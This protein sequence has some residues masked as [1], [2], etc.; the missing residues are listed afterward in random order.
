MHTL[1]ARNY[2]VISSEE[3]KKL[4]DAHV[5]VVGAGGVGGIALISLA[6]M[7][8][9]NIHIVDMDVFEHSNIN[10]QMLSSCSR[11]GKLKA[12]CAKE[13]LLDINPNINVRIST[14][15]CVEKN[16]EMLIEGSDVVID[17]TDTLISRVIIHRTAQK[18][19]I[20]SVWIAVTPPFRGGVM[21]FSDQTPPYELVLRHPSYQQPLTEEVIAQVTQIKNERANVS[22]GFGALEDWAQGY[23]S[24]EM[25]W[26]VL[27]P[28]ANLVGLLASFEAFKVI[29][30]RDTL[31]P[32]Y[33]PNLVKINLAQPEMVRVESPEDGS[34][35]NATL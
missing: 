8:I 28:V 21:T 2:G 25:P 18:M 6:R 23:L 3:Q 7:G 13:T 17:A 16:A 14:E 15:K 9:G 10:R 27:C 30:N 26:A 1:F 33:A 19:K 29:L 4:T 35:D 22:V 31:L 12:E 5:T 20:P 34:W 32:T 11:V 24:G